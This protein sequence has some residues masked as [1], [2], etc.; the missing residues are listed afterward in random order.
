MPPGLPGDWKE[1]RGGKGA[2]SPC[3]GG[4]GAL[5]EEQSCQG[6]G[7]TSP[8]AKEGP[9]WGPIAKPIA[10]AGHLCHKQTSHWSIKIRLY[11]INSFVLL[12]VWGG[13]CFLFVFSWLFMISSSCRGAH[14]CWAK[15]NG[16]FPGCAAGAGALCTPR[17]KPWLGITWCSPR[18]EVDMSE[19]SGW[20]S[21]SIFLRQP[22]QII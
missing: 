8:A 20:C 13:L 21:P 15:G 2:F 17:L 3:L 1:L 5:Q 11:L 4:S 18:W 10:Q 6:P 22:R 7:P 16:K 14:A 19:F 9:M 12:L